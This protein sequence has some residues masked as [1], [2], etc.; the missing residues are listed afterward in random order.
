MISRIYNLENQNVI[1]RQNKYHKHNRQKEDIIKEYHDNKKKIEDMKNKV[2]D[3]SKLKGILDKDNLSL[4]NE[5]KKN[6]NEYTD[7]VKE[8]KKMKYNS[9]ASYYDSR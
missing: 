3:I 4:Q 8:I 9:E 2:R 7:R 6:E 1:I 5:L